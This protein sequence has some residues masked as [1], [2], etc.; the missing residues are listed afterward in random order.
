MNRDRRNYPATVAE[1]EEMLCTSA[2]GGYEIET[3]GDRLA[4]RPARL[5]HRF[6]ERLAASVAHDPAGFGRLFNHAIRE[7][8]RD[9]DER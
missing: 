9:A 2:I 6:L 4:N 5:P 7:A 8:R 1:A 3:L